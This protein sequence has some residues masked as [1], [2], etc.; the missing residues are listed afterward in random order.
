MKKFILYSVVIVMSLPMAAFDW[1]WEK[2]KKEEKIQPILRGTQ[3]GV[4]P[5]PRNLESFPPPVRPVRVPAIP[6]P[7]P[8]SSAGGMPVANPRVVSKEIQDVIRLNQKRKQ[9]LASQMEKLNETTKRAQLYNRILNNMY[10]AGAGRNIAARAV[11]QEKIRLI[12]HEIKKLGKE[13]ASHVPALNTA[14]QAQALAER[15]TASSYMPFSVN[16]NTSLFQ[17]DG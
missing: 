6:I 13:S 14:Y 1:P 17:V 5:T 2:E 9:E 11:N 10:P 16:A 3:V 15:S 7:I 4:D 12:H 8:R